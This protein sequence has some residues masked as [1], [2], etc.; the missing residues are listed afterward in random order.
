MHFMWYYLRYALVG[1]LPTRIV[2]IFEKLAAATYILCQKEITIDEVSQACQMLVSFCNEFEDIYGPG[3]VTMNVHLLKHY[4]DVIMQCGPLWSYW[5][6][7]FENQIGT[8]KSLVNGTTDVLMQIA[9]KF[10]HFQN[11][12]LDE[13]EAT[14]DIQISSH[15]VYQ[16]TKINLKSEYL[17]ALVDCEEIS[18]GQNLLEIWKRLRIKREI[19]SCTHATVTKS[20]DYF[21]QTTDNEIGM[22]EF[23]F[24]IL[25]LFCSRIKKNTK[26]QKKVRSIPPMLLSCI[27]LHCCRTFNQLYAFNFNHI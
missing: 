27:Q 1:I 16:R 19:Y 6:F 13:I 18:Y 12:D 14:N 25:Q 11:I 22:I 3:A 9:S 20:I 17:A 10:E 4:Y 5:M 7:G 2:K 8:L 21:I 24:I 15:Y 26:I 23:F